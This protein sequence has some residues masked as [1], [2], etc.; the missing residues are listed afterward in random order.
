MLIGGRTMIP[1]VVTLGS[2]ILEKILGAR[3]PT[4]LPVI[5]RTFSSE[6]HSVSFVSSSDLQV[7]ATCATDL[8]QPV[9]CRQT[10]PFHCEL[11]LRCP[12]CERVRTGVF[13]QADVD[14]F[15]AAVD[16]ATQVLANTLASVAMVELLDDLD[17]VAPGPRSPSNHDGG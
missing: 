5:R 7:C 11:T 6:N 9:A 4:W 14:G 13:A 8:V 15:Y 1:I 12:N 17:R 16:R 3:W 10:G 2:G